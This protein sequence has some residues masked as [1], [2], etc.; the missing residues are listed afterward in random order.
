MASWDDLPAVVVERILQDVDV[1][2]YGRAHAVS[3]GV[4]Q[5]A[6]AIRSDRLAHVERYKFSTRVR[7]YANGQ[8]KPEYSHLSADAVI[9]SSGDDSFIGELLLAPSTDS[10]LIGTRSGLCDGVMQHDL[11]QASST[12]EW[13]VD[14]DRLFPHPTPLI[15]TM[16]LLPSGEVVLAIYQVSLL[17]I[18]DRRPAAGSSGGSWQ[19]M[20][21]AESSISSVVALAPASDNSVLAVGGGHY[22]DRLV[23][24]NGSWQSRTTPARDTPPLPGYRGWS[25]AV[26][27]LSC[28]LVAF[29]HDWD[30]QLWRDGDVTCTQQLPCCERRTEVTAILQLADSQL[31]TAS[32]SGQIRTWLH[33]ADEWQCTKCL[34]LQLL[35]SSSLQ[36]LEWRPGCLVS[37]SE[38]SVDVWN[39]G[40]LDER[41]REPEHLQLWMDHSRRYQMYERQT[42]ALAL[43]PD[44]RLVTGPGRLG[45]AVLTIW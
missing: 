39:V 20:G 42:R 35:E 8:Q 27:Q 13:I 43:L 40:P 11:S 12:H 38:Y 32:R 1:R 21:E 26:A 36:L 7:K 37:S 4:L 34:C 41:E 9:N 23:R 5:A 28:G 33:G 3:R 6:R 44:G 14:F 22:Y 17:Q 15:N 16:L 45:Q 10:V 29:G 30:V 18:W 19:L 31:A 25:R 24:T 2:S